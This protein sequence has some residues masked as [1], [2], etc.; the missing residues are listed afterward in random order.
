MNE[1]LFYCACW[2]ELQHFLSD[3]VIRDTVPASICI[4]ACLVAASLPTLPS[5]Q[6]RLLLL[7]ALCIATFLFVVHIR[8]LR[9]I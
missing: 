6:K 4:L 5:W 9:M 8:S 3:L 1:E 7:A 2:R